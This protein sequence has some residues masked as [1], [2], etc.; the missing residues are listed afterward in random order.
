MAKAE[1]V[2]INVKMAWPASVNG[3]NGGWLWRR[4]GGG[5]LS[6][7]IIPKMASYR[8]RGGIAAA[9]KLAASKA[10][11]AMK[12]SISKAAARGGSLVIEENGE[13]SMK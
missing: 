11:A 7:A 9:A 8:Q 1:N 10:K 13:I 3:E 2:N 4:N 6:T 5:W 12:T